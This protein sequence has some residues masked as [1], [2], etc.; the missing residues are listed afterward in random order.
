MRYLFLV[1]AWLWLVPSQANAATLDMSKAFQ[2]AASQK[3]GA[4]IEDDSIYTGKDI[5]EAPG[6]DA[7]DKTYGCL[8][9]TECGV[10]EMCGGNGKCVPVCTLGEPY[11]A[12]TSEYCKD[13][14]PGT[15]HTYQ[16]VECLTSEHCKAVKGTEGGYR[17]YENKCQKCE[18]GATDCGCPDGKVADGDGGCKV[19]PPDEET[20]N[21]DCSPYQQETRGFYKNADGTINIPEKVSGGTTACWDVYGAHATVNVPDTGNYNSVNIRMWQGATVN[22]SFKTKSL[23]AAYN[24]T[25]NAHTITFNDKVTVNGSIKWEKQV[26]LNFKGGIEGNFTCHYL[27]CDGNY[28]PCRDAGQVDCPWGGGSDKPDPNWTRDQKTEHCRKICGDDPAW[29]NQ[30]FVYDRPG[31]KFNGQEEVCTRYPKSCGYGC[32]YGWDFVYGT[33]REQP[34]TCQTAKQN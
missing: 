12:K 14:T 28:G 15:P 29:G 17:C 5:P 31:A 21:S 23:T 4:A 3:L 2:I 1:I 33:G 22:G 11:C 13:L 25:K 32:T 27:E 10:T 7:D 6:K 9:D 18:A 24:Y 16:C 8:N 26:Q 30:R 20:L 19:P 34:Y